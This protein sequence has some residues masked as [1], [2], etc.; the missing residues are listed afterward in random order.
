MTTEDGLHLALVTA[1]PPSRGSLNEYGYHFARALR[2]QPE[3]DALSLIADRLVTPQAEL[4]EAGEIRRVWGF[5]DPLSALKI[6]RALRELKPDAVIFN[7]QF[8][9]FGDKRVPAALGLFA[10]QLS[11]R[12]RPT[13]TLLHNLFETVDLQDAGFAKGAFGERVT[14]LAGAAFTRVLL[15]SGRVALTMPRYCEILQNKYG[16]KNVFHAPHG[17]FEAPAAPQPLPSA[18]TV[19]AFGKFGT[20][21]KVELLLE[22]HKRLL[23]R[24]DTVRLVIAGSDSPNAPGYLAAMQSLY[25]E[26]P[27]V[28]F[29]G[30]VAEEDVPKIFADATVAAF[31]YESTTGSSGVLHQA[32]Q[33]GRAAVMPN[34]GDLADLVVDEGFNAKFFTPGD[35]ESLMAALSSLLFNTEEAERMG[36]ANHRA[37]SVTL[38]EVSGRYLAAIRELQGWTS[39]ARA[40]RRGAP[41]T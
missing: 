9:S 5:N 21:K 26:L 15:N 3:V 1:Y 12:V 31:P 28:T 13:V 10:P 36:R 11:H 37:A 23:E 30:Y 35:V 14:R 17:S 2:A 7:L 16:A 25:R 41:I 33:F 8:A 22:A 32:G 40:P 4:P 34:I 20:Y 6:E 18:P 39:A 19:M 29:T 38:G 24:D 27:N